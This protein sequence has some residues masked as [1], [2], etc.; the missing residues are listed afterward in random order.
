MA[1]SRGSCEVALAVTS[2]TLKFSAAFAGR[3]YCNSKPG[4]C[5]N[6]AQDQWHGLG[7]RYE[8]AKVGRGPPFRRPTGRK[9]IPCEKL[10]SFRK[11]PRVPAKPARPR[12]TGWVAQPLW[13][14][15]AVAHRQ[16]SRGR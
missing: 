1:L 13:A 2:D 7:R 10:A 6:G 3:K 4:I 12:A 14:R 11:R 16:E 8:A 9:T 15:G 5:L